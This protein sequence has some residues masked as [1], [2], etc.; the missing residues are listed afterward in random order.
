VVAP[1][2]PKKELK[3]AKDTFNKMNQN[4]GPSNATVTHV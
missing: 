2:L 4:N 3:K 1:A